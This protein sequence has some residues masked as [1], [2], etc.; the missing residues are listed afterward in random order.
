MVN[1]AIDDVQG[2]KDP[3][4]NIHRQ[5]ATHVKF[6]LYTEKKSVHV[7]CAREIAFCLTYQ[8]L[9]LEMVQDEINNFKSSLFELFAYHAI[10]IY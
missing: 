7:E 6:V 10:S 3:T 2:C 5:A 9:I 4:S 1:V 8:D